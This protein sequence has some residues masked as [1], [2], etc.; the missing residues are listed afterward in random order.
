[1][2]PALIKI[3]GVL[4]TLALACTGTAGAAP[5][6]PGQHADAAPPEPYRLEAEREGR[7]GGEAVEYR[8]IVAE[9]FLG[10]DSGKPTA[11]VVSISYLRTDLR[12]DAD[13]PV[14][15]VF[16]GGPGSASLWLH[17][18]FIGPRRIDFGND[19]QPETTPPFRLADNTESPLDAADLVLFD[20]PGTG[21]SRILSGGNTEQYYGVQQDAG[22]TVDFIQAWIREH[23]R[24]NSPKYLM[25]ESYGTIRA[26]V[27]AKQLAGGPFGT[28]SMDGITLDGVIL[29]GQAMDMSGSAGRDGRFINSLPSLAATAWYHGKVDRDGS[30]LAQ[31]VEAA[32]RFAAGEYQDALYAGWA[33][34]D[35]ARRR[36]AE[37]LSVL[38]GLSAEEILAD[39]LRVANRDFAERLLAAE[40]K[41]VGMYDS[42]FVL[43]LAN[44]GDDPVADDPAMGQYV[45]GYVAAVNVYLR[46]ELG[47]E[48]DRSYDAIE[49][50]SINGR[51]DYGYGPGVPPAQN[52]TEDLATA[53]RRNPA[54]R[55]FVGTGYYD[56]VTTVGT[57]EYTLAHSG[58][59]RDRVRFRNYESGHMPYLGPDSRR[60]LAADIRRFVA[61]E[62]VP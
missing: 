48:L 49:F 5:N 23:G 41:E 36:I 2:H 10:D 3:V 59:E 30:T 31:H 25:G 9:T 55:I 13:R 57:A 40:G 15:F 61:G 60:A 14:I 24:W 44:D 56:L 28:G 58:I 53:S 22:A 17:M 16:N 52:F 6:P 47:V 42:R 46:Q 62:L 51:W 34:G 45:P 8:T 32:R 50:R 37:R 38:V 21:F 19:I 7:F 33:L 43:P 39:D 20:P 11:S 35:D 29:L 18:G 1:M 4:A 54:L 27:V 12:G 26:A